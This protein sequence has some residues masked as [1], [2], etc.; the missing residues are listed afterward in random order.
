VFVARIFNSLIYRLAS[1]DAFYGAICGIVKAA[2]FSGLARAQ[3]CRDGS[4]SM[5]PPGTKR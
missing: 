4:S 2:A 5:A 3:V 1:L